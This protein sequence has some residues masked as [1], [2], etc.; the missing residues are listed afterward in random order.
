MTIKGGRSKLSADGGVTWRDRYEVRR[1]KLR[2]I[3]I[4]LAGAGRM[5]RDRDRF[6]L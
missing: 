2:D 1:E 5:G 4:D 6:F 3:T